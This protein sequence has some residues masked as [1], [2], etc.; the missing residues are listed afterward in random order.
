MASDAGPSLRQVGTRNDDRYGWCWHTRVG[1]VGL[2]CGGLRLVGVA[3]DA[4][5]P[6]GE[7][8]HA[9]L[10]T[11]RALFPLGWIAGKMR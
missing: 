6:C 3:S 4:G 11:W 2:V 5:W 10:S 1:R 8:R 9:F 7:R